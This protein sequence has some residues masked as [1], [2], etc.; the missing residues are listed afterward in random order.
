MVS[1]DNEA[2]HSGGRHETRQER[3][4]R[5]YNELLQELRVA[6]TG[7]QIL[8]AFLL[9]LPFLQGFQIESEGRRVVYS[10]T[11]LC[12]ALSVLL[13]IAPVPFHRLVFRKRMKES[14]VQAGNRLA[15]AGVG[16]LLLAMAGALW[17]V[18]DSMWSAKTAGIVAGAFT[19][20][21][22]GL[23]AVWPLGRRLRELEDEPPPAD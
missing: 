9:S 18:F 12:T 11:L 7:V 5:N 17:L 3:V 22:V 6:Q 21:G 20:L 15:L 16:F 23:W 19:L 13:L 14:L 4:D 1:A 8:F 2:R 10:V